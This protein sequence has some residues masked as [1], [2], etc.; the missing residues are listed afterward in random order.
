MLLAL[1]Y[2]T[3]W[4]HFYFHTDSTCDEALGMTDGSI[5]NDQ[6]VA[7]SYSVGS[8]PHEGRLGGNAW[9]PHGELS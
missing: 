3:Y 2:V 9:I 4:F 6:I 8:E 5:E 1:K 7:S